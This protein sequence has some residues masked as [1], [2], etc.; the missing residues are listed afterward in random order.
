MRKLKRRKERKKVGY[1]YGLRELWLLDYILFHLNEKF[2]LVP[3]IGLYVEKS[4]LLSTIDWRL[5][6]IGSIFGISSIVCT[7]FLIVCNR[8]LKIF[9][10]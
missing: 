4:L 3:G 9:T 10:S 5:I 7:Y 6:G 2:T 8:L 1:S